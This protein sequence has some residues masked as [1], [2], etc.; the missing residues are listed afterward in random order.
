MFLTKNGTTFTVEGEATGKQAYFYY[1]YGYKSKK[2]YVVYGPYL[3]KSGIA[4]FSYTSDS[5]VIKPFLKNSTP[6]DIKECKKIVKD[7][8]DKYHVIIISIG[9]G[10]ASRES[11]KFCAE[12][13]QEE[14]LD[15]K[16][17]ITSEAGASIYSASKLAIEEF[18]DLA[19]EKRSAV[20]IARRIQDPL[21]EL[22]KIDPKSIGVGGTTACRSCPIPMV[23]LL[24]ST[25]RSFANSTRSK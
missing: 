9:N 14:K 21:S 5:C 13:I 6:N 12:L 4:P 19:V 24:G 3:G 8:I 22:V 7:L 10:T 18:P 2:K 20:S 1:I 17:I 11:E 23:N 25:P 16:Y 15:C